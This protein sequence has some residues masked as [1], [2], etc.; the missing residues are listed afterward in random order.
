MLLVMVLPASGHRI[1]TFFITLG[2]LYLV[3]DMIFPR[4]PFFKY[5]RTHWGALFYSLSHC[6]HV[7]LILERTTTMAQIKHYTDEQKAELLSNPYTVRVTDCTTTFSLAFKQ[8]VISNI[9]K[10]G[11]T[12][13]KVFQLAGYSDKFFSPGI[14]RYVVQAI[15]REAASPEGLQEPAVI[16]EHTPRKKHSETE[17]REL[18]E[19]VSILEQQVNF[20]KKSQFLKKQNHLKPPNNTD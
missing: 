19:R 14:R 5:G 18:Q 6:C 2:W 12:A 7:I 8:L 15:R 9:D 16:K 1:F 13:S 17:F 20:L 11:M 4:F 3:M 10:P